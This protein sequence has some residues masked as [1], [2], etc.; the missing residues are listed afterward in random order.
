MLPHR[1]LRTF[2]LWTGTLLCVLIAAAFVVSG[3][4]QLAVQVPTSR[5]PAIILRAGSVIFLT[6]E[7]MSVAASADPHSYS[8]SRWNAWDFQLLGHKTI[9]AGPIRNTTYHE[10]P[11]HAV[12]VAVAVP[13]LLLWRFWPKPVKRGHC[14]CGYDL[15]GNER[16]LSGVRAGD[17][18]C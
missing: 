8:L 16:G 17:K 14:R 9:P 6:D 12:F 11:L 13:T 3:W 18:Q 1:R 7:I 15:T 2:T 10:V 4:W 5:G